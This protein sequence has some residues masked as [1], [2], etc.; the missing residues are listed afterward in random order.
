MICF[1][2]ISSQ[3]LDSIL[4][5]LFLYSC[6]QCFV[7]E[8]SRS[9]LAYTVCDLILTSSELVDSFSSS[10]FIEQLETRQKLVLDSAII[11]VY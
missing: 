7:S 11:T 2:L 4:A 10:I 9:D 8:N 3:E 6:L 1:I 5:K